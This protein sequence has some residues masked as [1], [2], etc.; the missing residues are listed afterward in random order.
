MSIFPPPHVDV[1]PPHVDVPP[2]HVDIPIHVDVP[3]HV[4]VPPPHVD[5]GHIDIPAP[6][7]DIASPLPRPHRY[8]ADP[9]RR[10][11]HRHA[12]AAH[13]HPPAAARRR[14]PAARRHRV[15]PLVAELAQDPPV[16][17]RQDV[18]PH[19]RGRDRQQCENRRVRPSP[20]TSGG[21][22]LVVLRCVSTGECGAIARIATLDR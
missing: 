11:P 8:S 21:R 2:P 18:V 4:D 10:Q 3:V 19:V 16:C 13:G 12:A 6:H 9:H 5:F 1:P 15:Q 14:G 22:W 20:L 17:R 7:I